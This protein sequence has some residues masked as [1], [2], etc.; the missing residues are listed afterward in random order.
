MEAHSRYRPI[1]ILAL[2]MWLAGGTWARAQEDR[3][4]SGF[5]LKNYTPYGNCAAA[6]RVDMLTDGEQPTLFCIQ[7][8]PDSQIT[9]LIIRA[10]QEGLFWVRLSIGEQ[11]HPYARIP[12]AIRI[13]NGP[14][15]SRTANWN[16]DRHFADI[17][18]PALARSLLDEL[19]T[20]MRVVIRV[21]LTQGHIE[22]DGSAAAIADFRSRIGP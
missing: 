7:E 17:A 13:D 2:G 20:G 14:I 9:G 3:E 21:G 16:S 4:Y 1:L 19:A 15:I 18:D 22:L 6:T 5:T 11:S 10:D 8:R 12:V